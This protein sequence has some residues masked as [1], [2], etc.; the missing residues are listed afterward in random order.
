M[1][2]D[3]ARG[4]A[5]A[6]G[7]PV[8]GVLQVAV[9]PR[10]KA[11][12]ETEGPAPVFS[13]WRA[14]QISSGWSGPHSCQAATTAAARSHGQVRWPVTLR[15]AGRVR[16]RNSVTTPNWAFPAPRRAQN[17]SGCSEPEAVSCAPSAVTRVTSVRWS[18]VRP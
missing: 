11:V 14:D 9:V 7:E 18:Q 10:E 3:A 17:R 5:D 12:T 4:G 6:V 13:R 2:Q 16:K 15:G 8:D 1:Q